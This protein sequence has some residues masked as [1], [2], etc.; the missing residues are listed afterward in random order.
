MRVK[1][2]CV[3]SSYSIVL[4]AHRFLHKYARTSVYARAPQ[5][6]KFKPLRWGRMGLKLKQW[7]W[8]SFRFLG[9]GET[10]Y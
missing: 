8:F 7:K 3:S 4:Y 9:A 1:G 2:V 10:S 5:V 6:Q